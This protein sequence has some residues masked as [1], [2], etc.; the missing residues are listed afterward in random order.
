MMHVKGRM[1]Q[2]IGLRAQ[3][4][5][6]L[7]RHVVLSSNQEPLRGSRMRRESSGILGRRKAEARPNLGFYVPVQSTPGLQPS[8][9]SGKTQSKRTSQKS[10]PYTARDVI[11]FGIVISFILPILP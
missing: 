3:L 2:L 1:H 6:G 10:E 9:R 4:S 8:P 7:L 11:V 5:Q